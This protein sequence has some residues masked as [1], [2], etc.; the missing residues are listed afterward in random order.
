MEAISELGLVDVKLMTRIRTRIIL[1][2]IGLVF[3]GLT[4]FPIEWELHF[5]YESVAS[6]EQSTAFSKW[7]EY[8]FQGVHSTNIKYPFI[9]YGTDWLGFAHLVIAIAFWGP[10]KNPLQ[11]RWV[12]E[13]GIISCVLIFPFAFLAGQIREIPIFWRLID[14]SFGIVGGVVLWDC[15]TKIKSL[16]KI[17]LSAA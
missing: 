6:W 2:M 13:F 3:S 16:E 7:I 14:C 1:V 4:A 15:L 12:I 8:V 5:A 9:S 10:L 17:K 11:N